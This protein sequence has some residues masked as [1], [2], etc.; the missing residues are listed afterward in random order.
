MKIDN[1]RF[2]KDLKLSIVN[3]KL[4]L[5]VQLPGINYWM[6]V[7]YSQAKGKDRLP[8]TLSESYYYLRLSASEI[9]LQDG[10]I[11]REDGSVY[12]KRWVIHATDVQM[13]SWG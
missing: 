1:V 5:E 10:G 13:G 12:P 4:R 3:G 11:V 6:E 9:T 8:H 2:T 7:D